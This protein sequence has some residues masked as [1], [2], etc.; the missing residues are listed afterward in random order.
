MALV[1]TR[2]KL[3]VYRQRPSP[4]SSL[5]DFTLW[6]LRSGLPIGRAKFWLVA[7]IIAGLLAL[8]V[9]IQPRAIGF[10][11]A[12]F[13]TL[14]VL[15]S[16]LLSYARAIGFQQSALTAQTRTA[17]GEALTSVKSRQSDLAASIAA[18]DRQS[19]EAI[20]AVRED[21]S[22]FR[23]D[24]KDYVSDARKDREQRDEESDQVRAKLDELV[25]GHQQIW[26]KLTEVASVHDKLREDFDAHKELT[27]T[28]TKQGE[29]ELWSTLREV[30][31]EH[32]RL[33]GDLDA[34][35]E[36]TRHSLRR[37]ERTTDRLEDATTAL[38][39]EIAA[40]RTRLESSGGNTVDTVEYL[41]I[42][43][44]ELRRHVAELEK[45]RS[46]SGL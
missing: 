38:E 33:R 12:G 19:S 36:D 7:A 20:G 11:L 34:H 32:D 29:Q 23:K 8:G 42:A 6:V 45:T 4:L 24:V 39:G 9:L 5:A 25:A 10:G 37:G 28:A 40:L 15:V 41:C 18:S 14:L 16:L 1:R 44:D 13:V 43:I 35:K 27:R 3:A 26:S 30:A 22:S 17:F 31:S 21:M 2:Q 46:R